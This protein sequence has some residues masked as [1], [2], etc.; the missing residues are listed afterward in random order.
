MHS[1][2]GSILKLGIK[3][4]CCQCCT[5]FNFVICHIHQHYLQSDVKKVIFSFLLLWLSS[6]F[7]C[8]W[9]ELLFGGND[10]A[11]FANKPLRVTSAKVWKCLVHSWFIPTT[12]PDKEIYLK[13]SRTFVMCIICVSKKMFELLLFFTYEGEYTILLV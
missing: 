12:G 2:L 13:T 7:V 8:D 1:C 5:T 4:I 10:C 11:S 6:H 3:C 9:N